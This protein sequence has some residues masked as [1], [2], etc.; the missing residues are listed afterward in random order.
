MTDL[1]E[2]AWP[3]LSWTRKIAIYNGQWTLDRHELRELD[4]QGQF[5]LTAKQLLNNMDPNLDIINYSGTL[6]DLKL[7]YTIWEYL[8][9][10]EDTKLLIDFRLKVRRS[11]H[12]A[13]VKP[14][15]NMTDAKYL[16]IQPLFGEG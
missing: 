12:T 9:D 16:S 14:P 6:Y 3:E 2:R 8:Q 13:L 4:F 7:L 11:L 10:T 5:R 1:T 15:H